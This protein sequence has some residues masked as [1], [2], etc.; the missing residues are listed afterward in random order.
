MR[1]A[2]ATDVQQVPTELAIDARALEGHRTGIGVWLGELVTCW[3]AA[4]HRI[5]L[6]VR[7]GGQ[8][9]LPVPTVQ[10]PSPFHLSAWRF[11]HRQRCRYLSPD[12]MIVPAA[13]GATASVAVHD[14]VPLL[15]ANAQTRRT[16]L[17]FR[18]LL[19]AAARRCAAVIVP[20]AATR[21][22]LLDRFPSAAGRVHVVAEA[23]RAFP[24]P[25]Q[26]PEGVRPP[27]VLF[28]GTLEPRKKPVELV[29]AF[30]QAAPPG[31]QL[32]LAGKRGWL[33]PQE[34]QA[35]DA[36][37]ASTR[38][39]ELGYVSDEVLAG[40]LGAAG[41]LAYPSTYEGFG[42]PVLEA[43][44]A[45]VPVLTTSAPALREVAGDA[46]LLLDLDGPVPF[47]QRLEESL[48]RL[49]SD[50]RLREALSAAGRKRAREF[51]WAA[52]AAALWPLVT[53]P[54]ARRR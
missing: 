47:E 39:R 10:L 14:L 42:L 17:A 28:T 37:R 24:P 16:R 46:A 52:A 36:R 20:S 31:W 34:R 8:V 15:H 27:Y 7:R 48:R 6:L 41:A 13:L 53:G 18:L 32:V 30:E 19:P 43:M 25:G 54:P 1:V 9:E 5:T 40:L 11:A 22:D 2:A 21:D 44:A 33:S 12:S 29:R 3:A 23:A 50:A 38:V 26:L 45:G 4:G 49:L 35:L 51:S